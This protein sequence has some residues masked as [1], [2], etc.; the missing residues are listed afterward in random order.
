MTTGASV[1]DDGRLVGRDREL[2]ELEDVLASGS[3]ALVLVVGGPRIG[4]RRLLSEFRARNA[5]RSYRLIPAGPSIDETRL[6][7]SVD[8]STTVEAFRQATGMSEDSQVVRDDLNEPAGELV[9]IYGYRPQPEFHDWFVGTF[10]GGLQGSDV[11]Q[12]LGGQAAEGPR[13]QRAKQSRMIVVAGGP[14][15]LAAL[16]GVAKRRIELGSLPRDDVVAE[17]RRID[18][19]IADHLEDSE[20]EAYADA[21]V[22]DPALLDDLRALLPLTRAVPAGSPTGQVS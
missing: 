13:R 18:A 15:D 9:L 7:L 14:D 2:A 6:W 5:N 10:L 4:K 20:L 19:T 17:L 8:N 11:S 3:S 16:D 1:G 22:D 21:V 12:L